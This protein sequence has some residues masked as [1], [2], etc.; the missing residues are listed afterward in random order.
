M[1]VRPPRLGSLRV[2][3]ELTLAAFA[4]VFALIALRSWGE[5]WAWVFAG[6][7]ALG[8]VVLVCGAVL[9]ATEGTEEYELT[10]I[11]DASEEITG[12]IAAYIVP[13]VID[14]SASALNATIAG[15]ALALI[16]IVHVST[17]R[18]H[19]NPLLYVLG[20][21]VYRARTD[22]AAYVLIARSDV[23]DWMGGR[24]LVGFTAGV[25]VEKWKK[26]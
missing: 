1:I 18:V 5:W 21:R 10:E 6:V 8:L 25:L 3:A 16:V 20:Y 9:I 23:A 11:D 13:V 22:K 4:P 14:T 17:G 24:Q 12:Y 26:G 7:A 19:V 15:A 2:R